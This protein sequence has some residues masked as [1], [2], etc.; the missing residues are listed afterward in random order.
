[1]DRTGKKIKALHSTVRFKKNASKIKVVSR[2]TSKLDGFSPSL[3]LIDE[4]EEAPDTK[5]RDVMESGMGA[6]ESSCIIQIFTAGF[7]LEYPAYESVQVAQEV[8][9]G[10][11]TDD[12]SLYFLYTHD[13]DDFDEETGFPR[14]E[15]WQKSNPNLGVSAITRKLE[16]EVQKAINQRSK[17]TGVLTKNFNCWC[18]GDLGQVWIARNEVLECMDRYDPDVIKEKDVFVYGGLDLSSVSDLTSCCYL[19]YDEDAR[20]FYTKFYNWLPPAALRG[21]FNVDFYRRMI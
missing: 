7:N 3:A 6:R 19:W 16:N 20:K 21:E 4:I 15:T 5:M 13:P 1:M 8:L 14:R 11:K 2:D 17:L 12:S 18:N 10:I 9:E